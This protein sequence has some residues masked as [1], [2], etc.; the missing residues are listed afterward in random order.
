M[1]SSGDIF[2]D[3]DCCLPWTSDHY[4]AASDDCGNTTPISYSVT[5]TGEVSP[6]GAGLSGETQHTDG[7]IV[8]GGGL[9]GKAPFR[10]LG[11][12]PNPTAD[13]T[14]LQFEVDIAQRIT[15]RLHTMSGEHVMD[16]FDGMAEPG[17]AYQV[18]I[19]VAAMSAGL[20][21]LRLSSSLHSEVRKLLIA[22]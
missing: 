4:Y 12:N 20:Y 9:S 14:Q 15:V 7:P 11:L 3:L 6:D 22:D 1:A 5:N 21:Q 18:E 16:V 10:V 19:G 13:L 2:V 17:A 8:L